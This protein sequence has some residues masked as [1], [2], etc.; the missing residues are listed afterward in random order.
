MII[1][2]LLLA[3]A[4]LPPGWSAA[5]GRISAASLRGN[6]SFLASDALEGRATPSRGLEAAAEFIASRF[7]AAGL[8]AAGEDGYFQNAVVR[9]ERVRNVIGLLRGSDPKL[10]DTYV[11]LTAHY[12][13]V[14]L[15]RN[16]G[17]GDRVHNGANDNASGVAAVIEI[18]QSL[19]TMKRRP[20]RTMVFVC[21]F[22][23][24][25]G[26]LGSRHY[27]EKPPLPLEDTV[28]MI[29]LEHLGRTDAVKG[30]IVRTIR[31]TGRDFSGV[32]DLLARAGKLTGIT[33]DADARSTDEY[34]NRSDNLPFALAGVPAHTLGVAFIFPDYHKVSDEWPKIDYDNFAAVTRM[35]AAG[36]LLTADSVRAPEWDEANPHREK[37]MKW[38]NGL[39]PAETSKKPV[40][41][42][43]EPK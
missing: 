28:A 19:A 9:E 32:G 15:A 13:H 18:A 14:G 40:E 30:P 35:I 25:G 27:V 23:E 29:N 38:P 20:K 12:D 6:V 3:Q 17:E 22:G 7:R 5:L 41:A 21:F 16:G 4:A 11:L 39:G 37:Y 24:E 43:A 36:M 42:P 8:E 31:M 34:F 10:K 26:M 2:L 33:L 1:A